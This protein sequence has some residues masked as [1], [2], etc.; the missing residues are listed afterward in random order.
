MEK[1]NNIRQHCPEVENLMDGKMPFITRYGIT[2]V[3]VAFIAIVFVMLVSGGS[4]QQ[5]MMEIINH[6]I[7]QINL[8]S[9]LAMK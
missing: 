2:F 5:L 3:V 6:T 8:N 4:P 7:K 9:I 1:R